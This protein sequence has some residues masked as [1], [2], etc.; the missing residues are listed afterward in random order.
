MVGGVWVSLQLN[1]HESEF[2]KRIIL[3]RRKKQNN[4][5][6]NDD[7]INYIEL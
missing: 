2:I 6:A 3:W 4:Y 1:R 5:L 7:S